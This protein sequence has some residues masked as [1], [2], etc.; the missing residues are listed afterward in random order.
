MTLVQLRYFIAIAAENSITDAARKLYIVQPSLTTSLKELETELDVQLVNRSR[1]GI[2]LTSEGIEFLKKAKLLVMQADSLLAD[3]QPGA[4]RREIFAVSCLHYSF[5]V[6]AF[7]SM[8]QDSSW[9]DYELAIRETRTREVIFDTASQRS[10]IGVLY[11]SSFNQ[12]H[13]QSLLSK[14]NLIFSPICTCKTYVYLHISHP[15]ADHPTILMSELQE[16]A[17]LSFEQGEQAIVFDAEEIL[18]E[19]RYGKIIKANDRATMLNLMKGLNGYTL[20]SGIISKHLNGPDYLAVPFEDDLDEEQTEMT[21]GYITRKDHVLSRPA[22]TYI[23]KIQAA[24]N[25]DV[26]ALQACPVF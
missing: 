18:A 16:Y 14:N 15:L 26:P 10:E 4:K 6:D 1:K 21:I 19:S 20:C 5:A 17:C 25:P 23:E 24:A 13:I 3:Y 12:K 7:V 8:V 9:D 11:L 2:S 22:R